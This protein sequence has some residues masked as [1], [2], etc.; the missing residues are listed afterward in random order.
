ML[1]N[2]DI[3]IEE[4]CKMTAAGLQVASFVQ[5]RAALI[6]RYKSVYG[7][8]IDLSTGTADGV[9]VNDLALIINNILQTMQTLYSNLDVNTASGVY[10]DA[11]CA[12]SN[13]R[14][15]S[16]TRS[17]ASLQVTNDSDDKVVITGNLEFVDKAGTIW[18][19][20]LPLGD[21]TIT[22][23]AREV[24]QMTVQ[25]ETVGS[26]TAPAGWIYQTLS[27]TDLS[28]VQSEDANVGSDDETD[29]SLRSRR[30]Q[31]S[32]AAGVTVLESLVGA[33]L[34]ISG[35]EDVKVYNNNRADSIFAADGTNVDP[36]SVYVIIR[37]QNGVTIEDSTI[38][39][40]IH[41]KL[42]PGIHTCAM[43]STGTP[44]GTSKSYDYETS[45]YGQ[46]ISESTQ[47]I[48]WKQAS[49]QAPKLTVTI[50]TLQFFA[51]SEIETIA[52]AMMAY[53]NDY[54]L[55]QVPSTNDLLIEAVNAD[56]YFRG[57]PTYTVMSVDVA[58]TQH[59]TYYYYNKYVSTATTDGYN[60]VITG[61]NTTEA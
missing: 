11:L 43:A 51:T 36:H 9:F 1:L 38:G 17:N 32:G 33:L 6:A 50:K 58:Q 13:V 34:S 22:F 7:D 46:K 23:A 54:P 21:S 4:F 37:T 29:Y 18:I 42:T 35:I 20:E 40:I 28:V 16:A 19:Y 27:I 26:V 55:G 56:A 15:R 47:R 2:N 10:L 31:S 53:M 49:P 12:L 14:R 5:I 57:R 61:P 39:S 8:D 48:Y 59:D 24:K 41:N 45:V 30:S 60:I 3:S 25:C 44:F 52:K